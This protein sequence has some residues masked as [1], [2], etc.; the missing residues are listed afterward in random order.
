[1]ERKL[2]SSRSSSANSIAIAFDL[3]AGLAMMNY[4]RFVSLLNS[5]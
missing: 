1:L 5:A 3:I 4:F 2:A